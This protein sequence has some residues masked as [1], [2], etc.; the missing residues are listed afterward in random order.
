MLTAEEQWRI[1]QEEERRLRRGRRK[2]KTLVEQFD[3]MNGFGHDPDSEQALIEDLERADTKRPLQYPKD[4]TS[5]CEMSFG[6]SSFW[7]SR[8]RLFNSWVF[9]A[10]RSSSW[11]ERKDLPLV[12]RFALGRPIMDERSF[13]ATLEAMNFR[14]KIPMGDVRQ[15]Y[16]SPIGRSRKLMFGIDPDENS[17]RHVSSKFRHILPK[18][19]AE[20]I[21]RVKEEATRMV[22]QDDEDMQQLTRRQLWSV[23]EH[24]QTG[25]VPLESATWHYRDA[26]NSQDMSDET[27]VTCLQQF[28]IPTDH[29]A[30]NGRSAR[31][32]SAHCPFSSGLESFR[33][34]VEDIA[35]PDAKE[36]SIVKE[37]ASYV[38]LFRGGALQEH[39]VVPMIQHY[40]EG[41]PLEANTIG[42][43]L[44]DF[45]KNEQTAAFLMWEDAC[46]NYSMSS[47]EE[48]NEGLKEEEESPLR[49]VTVPC[50]HVNEGKD[51]EAAAKSPVD[52]SKSPDMPRTE[53]MDYQD[54]CKENKSEQSEAMSIGQSLMSLPPA[55]NPKY[56]HV[57]E[58]ESRVQPPGTPRPKPASPALAT[59]EIDDQAD[60]EF[61]RKPPRGR[62]N[63]RRRRPSSSDNGM[64]TEI[65]G[66]L[67]PT[68]QARKLAYELKLPQSTIEQVRSI[69]PRR[70]RRRR[71]SYAKTIVTFP[72]SKRKAS[73]ALHG[74][75]PPKSPRHGDHSDFFAREGEDQKTFVLSHFDAEEIGSQDECARCLNL[76]CECASGSSPRPR[77]EP[78][79][80]KCL[81]QP[82]MCV[83][84]PQLDEASQSAPPDDNPSLDTVK[85]KLVDR[86]RPETP[87]RSTTLLAYL[88]RVLDVDDAL[89]SIKQLEH[90]FPADARVTSAKEILY[91]IKQGIHAGEELDITGNDEQEAIRILNIFVESSQT[92]NDY[93]DELHRE[94]TGENASTTSV[95]NFHEGVG[96]GPDLCSSLLNSSHGHEYVPALPSSPTASAE[97]FPETQS[98]FA[99]RPFF[100]AIKKPL[101]KGV[102][103]YLPIPTS[104]SSILSLESS[105][106]IEDAVQPS[107]FQSGTIQDFSAAGG[108]SRA[109][110]HSGSLAGGE[111]APA[112]GRLST[113]ELPP[114]PPAGSS[115]SST[116]DLS[117]LVSDHP[118]DVED[119][120]D[121]DTFG[122]P[123]TRQPYSNIRDTGS[124]EAEPRP[125]PSPRSE[126]SELHRNVSPK[127]PKLRAMQ[128]PPSVPP[129]SPMPPSRE[130]SK[131]TPP[132]TP[133]LRPM[134]LSTKIKATAQSCLKNSGFDS[135]PLWPAQPG[136][137]RKAGKK[138]MSKTPKQ[139]LEHATKEAFN[140]WK[141]LAFYLEERRDVRTRIKKENDFANSNWSNYSFFQSSNGLSGS[142][143]TGTTSALNKLFDKYRGMF[144]I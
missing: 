50:P 37:L 76:P 102:S 22:Q 125:P 30:T 120:T 91:H 132:A 122:A 78:E 51:Q 143:G 103:L 138:W 106:D 117:E 13:Q 110:P 115:P 100:Q 2:K 136:L 11:I 74:D 3:D 55:K 123:L 49:P 96:E 81:Q 71:A 57:N 43:I 18:G 77:S 31:R 95:D 38:R 129:P 101:G 48:E 7:E 24:V 14:L 88:A 144:D 133:R 5:E 72:K 80:P 130:L 56:S 87:K 52:G 16:T 25:S 29:I 27:L 111:F 121:R 85:G 124:S 63:V 32:G 113:A 45:E 99:S 46:Y 62:A 34:E 107:R 26:F 75:T 90:P 20:N 94:I 66:L 82:C 116:A 98:R 127:S 64:T 65:W 4:S 23:Y 97:A 54:G 118:V 141:S 89:A 114:E 1:I 10:S 84:H 69:S 19:A 58:A 6:E 105:S 137:P 126:G 59:E 8:K 104:D 112:G 79:C 60:V 140:Q 68:K 28:G 35:V 17:D 9:Q 40:L 139:A 83:G 47:S 21:D 92:L 44:T 12:F 42:D 73:M 134:E 109:E 108:P 33:Q 70:T 131:S 36:S 39:E 61:D 128:L 142:S 135:L 67:M 53:D 119:D 93:A 86:T 41:L 15:P